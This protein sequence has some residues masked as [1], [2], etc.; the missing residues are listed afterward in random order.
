[1]P[2]AITLLKQGKALLMIVSFK[3]CFLSV[4]NKA[5]SDQFKNQK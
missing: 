5:W 4:W 2:Q 1:M 3:F